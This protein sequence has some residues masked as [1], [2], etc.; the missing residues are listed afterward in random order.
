MSL[1]GL[2]KV[3]ENKITEEEIKAIVKEGLN[4]GEVQEVEHDLV[5]RVFNL[6]DRNVSSIM[7]HRSEVVWLDVKESTEQIRKK[8]G[9]TFFNTYPVVSGHIENIV[10][11]VYLKDMFGKIDNAGFLLSDLVRPALF[12]PENQSVYSTLELFKAKHIKFGIISNEFGDVLGIVTLTDI[13][14]ALVGEVQEQ[15][16]EQEIIE[17]EDGSVLVDGQCSFYVFLEY[18]DREDLYAQNDYNTLSGLILEELKHIPTAGEKFTW[19]D[20]EFE[21]VDMDGVRIDK[22]IV[23]VKTGDKSN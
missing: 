23:T 7:T 16:E 5:A 1:F 11:V 8:V 22:V 3:E 10:G 12:L 21:I 20:F 17:R 2:H 6:G 13:M 4:G 18:F 15:G 14:E 19:E 9:D